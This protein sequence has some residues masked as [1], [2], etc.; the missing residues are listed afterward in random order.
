MDHLEAGRYW[1]ANAEVWTQL[2]RCGYDLYRDHLN[3]PAFLDM[4]PEVNG[5]CGLD[6]GCGE[7][8]N[9]RLLAR[10]GARMTAIDISEV[11]VGHAQDSETQH[12]LGV[13]YQVASA[14]DL[15]F[16]DRSFDFAVA[17]MSL[18]EFPETERAL[19]EVSRVLRPGGFLQFSIEHPCFSTPH[20]RNLRDASGVTY[21]FEI[22]GYFNRPQ[23]VIEEWTFGAA[24]E[25]VKQGVRRFQ[26]PRFPRPLHEWINLLVDTGFVIERLGEPSPS[27]QTAREIPYLQDAQVLPY[28]LHVRVRRP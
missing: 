1:N 27:D 18:M 8:N 25:E 16:A 17:F 22:G 26:I 19:G 15:P 12:P 28:F 24:P 6:L 11:F 4:L 13:R 23:G 2:V 14:V 3:T 7:G 21:A 9:T 10:R 20:R 5:L